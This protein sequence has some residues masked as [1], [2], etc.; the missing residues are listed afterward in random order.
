LRID[1]SASQ[2]NRT[3][4]TTLD[5]ICGRIIFAPQSPIPV[6]DVVIDFFGIVDTW[7]DPV[8]PGSTRKK[9]SGVVRHNCEE[10][11]T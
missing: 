5:E 9:T 10:L 3:F 7:I 8:T 1:L 11:L 2:S 6:H 4:F